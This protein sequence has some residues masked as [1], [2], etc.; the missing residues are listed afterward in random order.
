MGLEKIKRVGC[1]DGTTSKGE[2]KMFL[3]R[4]MYRKMWLCVLLRHNIDAS[5]GGVTHPKGTH[6]VFIVRLAVH[7]QTADHG[8]TVGGMFPVTG[9]V[10]ISV[11]AGHGVI[12]RHWRIAGSV[13]VKGGEWRIG[14]GGR[15]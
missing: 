6:H 10:N 4:E 14:K 12:D 5:H 3:T 8:E 13:C 7:P 1:L 2:A 9:V 11:H 15:W